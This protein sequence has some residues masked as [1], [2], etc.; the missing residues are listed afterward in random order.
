MKDF[1]RSQNYTSISDYVLP[2]YFNGFEKAF[3]RSPVLFR[4]SNVR[5]IS[6]NNLS[7]GSSYSSLNPKDEKRLKELTAIVCDIHASGSLNYNIKDLYYVRKGKIVKITPYEEVTDHTG[8]K[9][10][11]VDLSG[12]D[13]EDEYIGITNNYSK[14]FPV[15]LSFIYGVP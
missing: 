12:I 6:N 15:G 7:T 4:V 9:K 13:F 2:N 8:E 5:A 3:S 11:K 14:D 1:A 10:V